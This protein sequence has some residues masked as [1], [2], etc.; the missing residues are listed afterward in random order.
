MKILMIY[1]SVGTILCL[2]TSFTKENEYFSLKEYLNGILFYPLAFVL[3][4]IMY[5]GARKNK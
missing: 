3:L 2:L 5:I 1:L 4:A